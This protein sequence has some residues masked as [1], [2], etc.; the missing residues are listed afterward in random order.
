MKV[1]RKVEQSFHVHLTKHTAKAE[2]EP[3][4]W[5][6][7]FQTRCFMSE[8]KDYFNARAELEGGNGKHYYRL[9]KLQEDGIADVDKLPFS[10]KVLLH[11]KEYQ[12]L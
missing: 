11:L 7:L 3:P 8:R 9:A 4:A 10:I 2:V 12:K 6:A 1:R 5:R